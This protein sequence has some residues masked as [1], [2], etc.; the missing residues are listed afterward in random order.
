MKIAVVNEITTA[1]RNVDV[2]SALE[3]RGHEILNLGMTG[4]P[5]EPELDYLDI[6]IISGITLNRGVADI[7]VGGCGSSQGFGIAAMQFP[8]VFCG[9]IRT[10]LDALLFAQINGGNCISLMLNQH[11]GFGSDLNL[12]MI[13]DNFFSVEL[14][15]GYPEHRKEPQ[16]I[17]RERLK[18]FSRSSHKNIQDIIDGL[19]EAVAQ[20]IS[21]IPQL[22]G[23][24]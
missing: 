22:Q 8:S 12:R 4:T 10:P 13:F 9:N 2:I 5:G 11:Y 18:A 6:G 17:A 16:R 14:G 19:P 7:V 1:G 20:K 15:V 24:L 3:G 23:F 21:S